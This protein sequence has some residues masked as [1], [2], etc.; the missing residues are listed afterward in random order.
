[1]C[2]SFENIYKFF[3]YIGI[4]KQLKTQKKKKKTNNLKLFQKEKKM[5]KYGPDVN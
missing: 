4:S 3:F 2:F 1:M 5:K